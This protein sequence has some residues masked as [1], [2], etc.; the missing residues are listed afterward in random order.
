MATLKKMV[1]GKCCQGWGDGRQ[2]EFSYTAD[3]SI[4]WFYHFGNCLTESTNIE[5]KHT[6]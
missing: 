2:L 4:R 1:E 3:G 6:L 5:Y